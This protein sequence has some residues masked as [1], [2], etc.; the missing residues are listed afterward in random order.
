MFDFF[1]GY[2]HPD[3]HGCC[4]WQDDE[5]LSDG[6]AGTELLKTCEK[7]FATFYSMS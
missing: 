7:D 5:C 4:S 3:V 1:Q 6:G 2:P